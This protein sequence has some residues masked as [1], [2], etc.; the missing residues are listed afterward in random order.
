M[1]IV[2]PTLEMDNVSSVKGRDGEWGPSQT[3]DGK[4]V[5]GEKD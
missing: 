5:A 1:S 3:G 4:E 2:Q